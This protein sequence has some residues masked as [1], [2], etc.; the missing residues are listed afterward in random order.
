VEDT[1]LDKI[2]SNVY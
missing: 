2:A 1:L